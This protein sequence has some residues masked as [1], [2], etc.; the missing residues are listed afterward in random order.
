MATE[1]AEGGSVE[2]TDQAATPPADLVV[3]EVRAHNF[4]SLVDVAIPLNPVTTYLVGENNAGK[5]SLLL[6][7]ATACGNR[8]ATTDDL[9]QARDGSLARE[10]RVD[11]LIRSVGDEF[12]D[13]VGQ[14][15]AANSGPG[16]RPGEWTG[17]RTT[18]TASR[19]GPLLATRR[20][21]LQWKPYS[22]E[23]SSTLKSMPYG[24]L[25]PPPLEPLSAG[26]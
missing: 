19:E 20:T 5:S 3:D 8:R 12:R 9:Y 26:M 15:L 13:Q 7:I 22:D 4:R 25:L 14:R 1:F 11:L 21:F 10:A 16:P 6:A 18:L 23:Q 17:I 2:D 24:L